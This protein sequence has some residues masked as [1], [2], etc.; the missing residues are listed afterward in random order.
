VV[1]GTDV[2]VYAVG[3][4]GRVESGWTAP[5]RW[6]R[7]PPVIEPFPIPGRRQPPWFPPGQPPQ[8]PPV[9][10]RPPSQARG[11]ETGLNLE[12]LEALTADTGG[13]TEVVRNARDLDPAT[14]SIGAELNQQ[15]YLGYAATGPRDGLW[16]EIEVQVK[17]APQYTVRHRRGYVAAP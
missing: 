1:R 5:P 15:Y 8:Y 17:N 3:I 7:Q 6:P 9:A 14:A 11:R 13:R 12:A 16:H 2:I 10:P 4:D